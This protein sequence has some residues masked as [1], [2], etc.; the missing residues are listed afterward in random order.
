M[1]KE[2]LPDQGD[3]VWLQFNPQVGHEQSGKRP[4][5]VLSPQIYN[6]KIGLALLCPITSQEKGYPFEV[7]LPDYL[8]IRGVVLSDQLKNLDWQKRKADFICKAP[9]E[10]I[11]EIREKIRLLI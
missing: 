10:I 6:E 4:A 8:E 7:K 3:I 9:E 11:A 1:V 2:Y 5:I